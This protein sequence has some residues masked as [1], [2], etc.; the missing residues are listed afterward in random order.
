MAF[1]AALSEHPEPTTATGEVVGQILDSIGDS[2]D[3]A[4]LFVT[5]PHARAIDDIAAA[6]GRT[7][8]PKALIG[9]T[10]VSVVG[11]HREAEEIPAVS[12]W[13]GHMDE[14][15]AVRLTA[16]PSEAGERRFD[17]AGLDADAVASAH[18]LIVLPDPYS[19]PADQ[20]LD[21][22]AA[23]RP[24][25]LVVGGLASA[26]MGP[27]GNRLVHDDKIYSDGAVA[28]AIGGETEVTTVVSQGCRPIGAPF[29][30]TSGHGNIINELGGKPALTRLMEIVAK[31]DEVDRQKVAQGL[32]L[33]R[34]VDEQNETFER[35][36]FLIRGVLQ[37]DREAGSIAIGDEIQLGDTVQFQV[38]D[39]PSADEDL[40]ALMTDRH[41]D[42]ALLFTCNGRGTH[43]FGVTDHDATVVSE[44]LS[45]APLAGM[46]CAGE[47]GPVGGRSFLHGFTASVALFR[48]PA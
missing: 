2:P 33:G 31:L 15:S 11:G 9:T 30:V 29:A 44:A 10:A 16:E 5:R 43:M 47:L 23:T 18:S 8:A 13:A 46:F 36:D 32:H 45:A 39:A 14:V 21:D 25:L 17:I 28:L 35:G 37:A 27:G 24:D 12:L 7:L 26:A 34:V 42:G 48:D 19:F 1:A 38:R 41:A 40:K 4:V 20:L 22:V 3:A 6:I